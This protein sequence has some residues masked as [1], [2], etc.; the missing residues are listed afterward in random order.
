MKVES[1]QTYR[2]VYEPEYF[3]N[4]RELQLLEQEK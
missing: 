2:M 3:I 1:N 4:E